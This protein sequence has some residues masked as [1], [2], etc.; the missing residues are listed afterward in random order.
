MLFVDR[1]EYPSN[2][3]LPSLFVSD[4][5]PT[6]LVTNNSRSSLQPLQYY[7]VNTGALRF[8]LYQGTFDRNDQF[9][10]SPFTDKFLYVEARQEWAESVLSAMNSDG[11]SDKRRIKRS[12]RAER[13]R[14]ER[15]AR[16]EVEEVYRDWL[17][18]M[19]THAQVKREGDFERRDDELTLGYVT[20]DVSF[21]YMFLD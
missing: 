4:A 17:A 6:A 1:A 2:G 20:Q 9:T 19:A 15:L 10:S 18:D 3:S 16:G 8:D 12:A 11:E 13:K 21:F 7:L 5:V 14:Q